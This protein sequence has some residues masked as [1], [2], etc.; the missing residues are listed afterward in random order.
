MENLLSWWPL[1][2]FVAAWVAFI[3]IIR[4]SNARQDAEAL[5]DAWAEQAKGAHAAA[6]ELRLKLSHGE[7]AE[8]H[9]LG[10]V[11]KVRDLEQGK[12][13][14]ERHNAALAN[15]AHALQAERDEWKGL[16]FKALA[17]AGATQNL[18][19]DA[20]QRCRAALAKHGAEIPPENGL[21]RL[22]EAASGHDHSTPTRPG[23]QAK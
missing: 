10:L 21:D 20:L 8:R 19:Y 6:D 16:Y 11:Q 1:A 14:L 15:A 22:M 5:R 7:D 18:L 12:A 23:T 4:L 13:G 9:T 3:R 17:E 2:L